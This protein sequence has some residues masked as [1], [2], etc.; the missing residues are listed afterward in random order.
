MLHYKHKYHDKLE[1]MWESGNLSPLLQIIVLAIAARMVHR[2][3][4]VLVITEIWRKRKVNHL[5]DVH[6]HWR[7]VDIRV[8]NLRDGEAKELANWI[9]AWAQYDPARPD[10]LVSYLHGDGANLH[11]HLQVCDQTKIIF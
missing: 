6:F 7:G 11:I 4:V 9:N 10:K 8:H 1:Q 3:N 5:A 2:Y